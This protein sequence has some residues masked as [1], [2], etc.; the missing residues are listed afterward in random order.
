MRAILAVAC[1]GLAACATDNELQYRST[2][3][4]DTRGVALSDDGLTTYAA[5]VG[6]T[7]AIDTNWG[8]PVSDENL[9]PDDEQVV[10]HYQGRTLAQ[11]DGS[12]YFLD[13]DTWDT[14]ADLAVP[15]LR[16][17]RLSDAGLLSLRSTGAACSFT[18]GTATV[19]APA[20][21]CGDD[22]TVAV[23]RRGA[24]VAATAQGVFRADAAGVRQ[25]AA[26]GDLV[27]VDPVL[28]HTYVAVKGLDQVTA[29][30]DDG[31]VLWIDQAPGPVTSVAVRGD[32]LDLLVLSEDPAG[33][34]TLRRIDGETGETVSVGRLPDAHGEVLTSYNGRTIAVVTH[35]FVNH[36]EIVVPGEEAVVNDDEVSC[37][38]LPTRDSQGFG[39]D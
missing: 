19:S 39:V 34:G 29:L 11:G 30:A 6:T 33:F 4:A 10:D 36:Y 31:T 24:I 3:Q 22:V 5:M 20:E 2:L 37:Q 1:V 15:G 14:S 21:L 26:E 27:S 32:K 23:D 38:N 9:P 28:G 35:G 17:A 7:C 18:A 13:G 12:L 25:I 8:C 16:A